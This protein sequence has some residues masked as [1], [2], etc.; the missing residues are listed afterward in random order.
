MIAMQ[1]IHFDRVWGSPEGANLP[2]M[3]LREHNIAIKL[4]ADAIFEFPYGDDYS[5]KLRNCPNAL[6]ADAARSTQ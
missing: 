6:N 1:P 4:N 5:I 3:T 2:R